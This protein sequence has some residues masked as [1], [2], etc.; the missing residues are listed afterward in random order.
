MRYLL[1]ALQLILISC[2]GSDNKPVYDSHDFTVDKDAFQLDCEAADCPS[3]ASLLLI[4]ETGQCSGSLINKKYVLTNSHCLERNYTVGSDCSDVTSFFINKSGDTVYY[5]CKS[6]KILHHLTGRN[7]S[8]DYA[9]IELKEA[10]VNI[11]S[12]KVSSFNSLPVDRTDV[13]LYT[14]NIL[15]GTSGII[16]KRECM[17][18]HRTF[19]NPSTKDTEGPMMALGYCDVISG[20]SGS[21]ILNTQNEL[22]GIVF[23]AKSKEANK[24]ESNFQFTGVFGIGIQSSCLNLHPYVLKLNASDCNDQTSGD[25]EL[26]DA[27]YEDLS[28]R[29][30]TELIEKMF[31]EFINDTSVIWKISQISSDELRKIIASDSEEDDKELLTPKCVSVEALGKDHQ[32]SVYGSKNSKKALLLELN[33]ALDLEYKIT[34]Q[35][36]KISSY[37]IRV[38]DTDLGASTVRVLLKGSNELA[39]EFLDVPLCN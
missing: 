9:L 10:P 18:R 21:G 23:A 6:I 2:G 4:G 22:V 19:L 35:F 28:S 14:A 13:Q 26:A 20:N 24:N 38:L 30:N 15:S 11:D 27:M 32:I 3:F 33:G 8:K 12:V 34:N 37:T 1:L 39:E 7:T 29:A 25:V 16:R 31:K 5:D 36:V 17:N